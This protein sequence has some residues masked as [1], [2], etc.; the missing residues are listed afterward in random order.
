MRLPGLKSLRQLAV[1]SRR[2][3][4][5][6]FGPRLRC[7]LEVQDTSLCF[8]AVQLAGCSQPL[9]ASWAPV[10]TS[11]VLISCPCAALFRLMLLL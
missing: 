10:L 6:I 5:A 11:W 7:G 3:L 2:S 8:L 4:K 9:E 1:F